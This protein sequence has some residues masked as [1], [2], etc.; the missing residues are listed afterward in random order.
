MALAPVKPKR[1][2]RS[3]EKRRT[4]QHHKHNEHYLKTYWP[5]IPL[6]LIVALG[7]V[8][9]SLWGKPHQG[10]LDYATD[11]SITNLLSETNNQRAGNGSLGALVLNSQLDNAAQAK[12][13]DMA[14]RNYWSHDTPDGQSPWTFFTAA[15]YQYQTAGE[16]LAYGFDTSANTVTAWMNSPGHRA[17]ILNTT[18]TE[19]GFGI[20]NAP[21]YQGTGPET[22]VVAEYASPLQVA[23]APAP[24]APASSTPS[25]KSSSPAAAPSASSPVPTTPSDSTPSSASQPEANT[26]PAPANTPAAAKPVAAKVNTQPITRLQLLANTKAAPWSAFAVSVIIT[27][28]IAVFLLRHGLVWHR[29]LRKGEKFILKHKLLDIILVAVAVLGIVLTRTVGVIR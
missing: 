4:G 29:V 23:A 6:S 16:N 27:V 1:A 7:F 2:G 9:N 25:V 21:N 18:Y 5:Y 3:H 17:N 13:N 19:V 22:I 15:G 28:S 12:A 14:A 20:A 11:V 26:T 10:V 8:V 24:A